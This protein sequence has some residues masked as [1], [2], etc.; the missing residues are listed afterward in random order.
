MRGDVLVVLMHDVPVLVV[1]LP[2]AVPL[3][4]LGV[5]DD[6]LG[7]SDQSSTPQSVLAS[8]CYRFSGFPQAPYGLVGWFGLEFLLFK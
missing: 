1:P 4:E 8:P 6:G 2:P 3:A 7:L 5:D